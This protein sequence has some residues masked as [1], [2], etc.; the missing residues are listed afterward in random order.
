METFELRY[1]LSVAK[2]ENIHRASE[3]LHVSPGSLSKAI[4]RIEGELGIKLFNREG[5]NI[6]LTDQGRYLQ[7]RA[8]QIVQLEEAT[9]AE[10]RGHQ[11]RLHVVMSGPEIFLSRFGLSVTQELKKIY[12][13]SLVEYHS[14]DEKKALN[15][16]GIGDA[17][18]AIVASET[19]S[20]LTSKVLNKI[21]FKTVV[22]EGHPLYPL[23]I[24]KKSIGI[25]NVL[26][27][28][29]VSP[30]IPFL[31]GVG[32]KQSLDGWRDDQFPRKVEYLTSSLKL[33]ENI[34]CAGKAIA[35]L[36]DYFANTLKV[37]PLKVSGCPYS[38]VQTIR[39]V[40]RNPKEISWI[41]DF[42][43]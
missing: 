6:R 29:F 22:G 38:C 32:L 25:K 30:T 35:Y 37:A 19:P 36:P 10:I 42:F 43:R 26:Q 27:Y 28:P 34:L 21:H 16:V 33:L 40:A 7:L 17:H 41:Y 1:F 31:G 9:K 18:L 20:H 8:S 3:K 5:R 13:N 39:L 12:P 15:E 2:H 4:T 24:A 14:C 23:A 11:N